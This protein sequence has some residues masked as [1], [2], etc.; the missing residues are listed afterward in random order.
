MGEEKREQ[1]EGREEEIKREGIKVEVGKTVVD[2]GRRGRKQ[3]K[4]N[5]HR[6]DI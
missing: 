3:T 1:K 4:C 5:D 6:S 2:I